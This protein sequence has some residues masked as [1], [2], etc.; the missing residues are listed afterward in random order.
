MG[1]IE[2]SLRQGKDTEGKEAV[3]LDKLS[4]SPPSW[5]PSRPFDPMAGIRRT[6]ASR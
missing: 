4:L 3:A 1:N 5:F 6:I 2:K